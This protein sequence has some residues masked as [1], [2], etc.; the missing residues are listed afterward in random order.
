EFPNGPR[1]GTPEETLVEWG[2]VPNTVTKGP[3][4]VHIFSHVEWHM[5][6]MRAELSESH[7]DY[8]WATPKEIL[9]T[10]A[11][12]TAFKVFLKE[13]EKEKSE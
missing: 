3:D 11:V 6:G 4:G 8:T 2:I 13:M 5:T 9:D 10:Y 12:P 1:E 7:P